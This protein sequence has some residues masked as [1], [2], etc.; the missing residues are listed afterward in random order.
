MAITFQLSKVWRKCRD[1]NTSGIF[2]YVGSGLEL[3]YNRQCVPTGSWAR[4]YTRA[5]KVKLLD[6]LCPVGG[7][8]VVTN[9]WCIT[10]KKMNCHSILKE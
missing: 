9:D 8:V 10:H 1:S 7:R 2:S 4:A 6:P 3:G 5:L